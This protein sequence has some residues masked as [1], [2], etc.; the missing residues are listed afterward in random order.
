MIAFV[1]RRGSVVA[2]ATHKR[3][4]V[5][6]RWICSDVVLP[7]KELCSHVHPLDPGVSG[8][9]HSRTVKACVFEYFRAPKMAA[10]LYAPRRVEMAYE[11]TGPACVNSGEKRFALD[12]R[13]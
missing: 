9:L 1:G 7:G 11:R 2:C 6:L 10:G 8:Y 12:T 5:G 13:L 3:E 4:T